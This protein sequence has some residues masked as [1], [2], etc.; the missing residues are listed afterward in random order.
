MRRRLA[1]AIGILAIAASCTG[2]APEGP[3]GALPS[4]GG[5]EPV[6]E[7]RLLVLMDDGS[8]VTTAPDGGAVRSLAAAGG[9]EV[10]VRH[11]I[12]SPDGH[13]VA[14]AEFEQGEQGPA[15]RLVTV[16]PTGGG[17][18]EFPVDTATFFLSWDPTSSRIAYLG[19]FRGSIGMGVAQ[20][21]ADG[22]PTTSTIGAG[23]PFY[24]SW[25]PE[26]ERLLIHV[27]AGTLGTLDL[28]GHLEEIGDRPAIFQAPVWLPDGR[29]VYAANMEGRQ[30]LVVRG[31]G[32]PKEL[33]TFEGA[34]EFVV[35]PDA[36]RVAYRVNDG[37]GLDGVSV[38]GL[39]S[40]RS[41]TVTDA[42]TSAFHWSPD[43][44]HLLLMTQEE[45]DQPATH[46][47][48]VWDGESTSRIGLAFLPSPTF[49]REYVPFYGQFAQSMT[50]WS[51]EGT[52]FAFPGLIED[53]A[54]IWVQ[55]LDAQ[56]PEFVVEGGRVVSWSPART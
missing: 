54:G 4:D 9:V 55:D 46:R 16:D 19:N 24:L 28:E 56:E 11:P 3:A 31:D 49:L 17:R 35:S 27:G 33:V 5:L 40:A 29:M 53:R 50:P 30:V 21:D 48:M 7:D 37:G 15:S 2:R 41:R 13:T 44:S 18:T 12:W 34:I 43:G 25:S 6:G 26:G 38:V 47:W 8:I 10:E 32:P 42:P 51:P 45:G 23:Q 1:A 20:R 22:E 52:S 36:R 39:G 14:W